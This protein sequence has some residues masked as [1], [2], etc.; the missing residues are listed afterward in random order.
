MHDIPTDNTFFNHLWHTKS[1]PYGSAVQSPQIV[2]LI[3][4]L[5]NVANWLDFQR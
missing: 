3:D 5:F 4:F 1:E 2:K